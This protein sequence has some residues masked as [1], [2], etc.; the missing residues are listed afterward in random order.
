MS[1]DFDGSDDVVTIAYDTP[2]D[3]ERTDTFSFT[4][5]TRLDA[6]G[7]VQVVIAK[8]DNAGNTTG[9]DFF[10]GSNDKLTVALTNTAGTNQIAAST[11]NTLSINRWY[12][13]AATYS[14]SGDVSGLVLYING[15]VETHTAETNNLTGS[16]L[17]NL[18]VYIG[19]RNN[20]DRFHSGK[21][22]EVG[23]YNVVLTK[24]EILALMAGGK[25][26]RGLVAYWPLCGRG[27]PGATVR[28]IS[29]N[30]YNG[31]VTG[32]LPAQHP[33][34]E[35]RDWLQE[36]RLLQDG[37]EAPAFAH[38]RGSTVT[39]GSV[40][41]QVTPY[42]MGINLPTFTEEQTKDTF[43]QALNDTMRR[44]EA[45]LNRKLLI[46]EPCEACPTAAG[47]LT[48][49]LARCSTWEVDLSSTVNQVNIV[50]GEV[51][52]DF[53]LQFCN[54]GDDT[55]TIRGWP[56]F[57]SS[58]VPT[59]LLPGQCVTTPFKFGSG[60][61]RAG[62]GGY[63]QL[64][65]G[66]ANFPL[67]GSGSG[68]GGAGVCS[69]NPGTSRTLTI[70]CCSSGCSMSCQDRKSIKLEACGGTPGANGY[71]WA[72]TAGTLSASTGYSVTL[73]P[74]TNTGS[75]V[76]GD[77]YNSYYYSCGAL[78]CALVDGGG[79]P[80]IYRSVI[81][82]GCNDQ[83]TV[84][85]NNDVDVARSGNCSSAVTTT[86]CGDIPVGTCA[87]GSGQL[88]CTNR[89]FVCDI[90]TAQMITDGCQPCGSVMDG[91]VVTVTDSLSNSVTK[92]INA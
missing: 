80:I 79:N 41:G 4:G 3:F 24:G 59:S 44:L 53:S 10:V 25:V 75:G 61:S 56:T 57:T 49:D 67:A 23:V 17:N 16:I 26:T 20:A 51:G 43:L 58:G 47:I 36:T 71:T 19:S 31:T 13:L 65:T 68:G 21:I 9:W 15:A 89:V 7:A 92:E 55:V 35:C 46:D 69:C 64:K 76:A 62:V 5:W 85:C 63:A 78:P 73:T 39:P 84:A 40:C 37:F 18:N 91:V 90:R 72:T 82:R 2:F 30:G 54:V 32:A 87:D 48:F 1:L 34:W 11:T 8:R 29:G 33:L 70:Q 22:A 77:A 28:D 45:A 86:P 66:T 81:S 14:G 52:Q 50:N 83:I 12:H 60:P 38:L 6:A 74:P 88:D 27:G 42:T